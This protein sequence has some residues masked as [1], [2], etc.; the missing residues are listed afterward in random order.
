MDKVLIADSDQ[1]TLEKIKKGFRDLH[2]FEILTAAEGEAALKLLN[3]EKVAVFVTAID[4]PKIPG[5]DLIA[6]MTR[7]RPETPCIVM[8]E[9]NTPKPWFQDRTG[10][11]NVLYYLQKPFQF[12]NLASAIFVGQNLKD[13]GLSRRGITLRNFLPL[14]EISRKTCRLDITSGGQ[15]Q[16]YLY[17]DRGVLLNAHCEDLTGEA[18]AREMTKWDR[19]SLTISELPKEQS[20][21]VIKTELMEIARALWG[22]PNAADG[23]RRP[24]AAENPV[25]R[26]GQTKLQTAVNRY[27]GILRTVKGYKGIAV[28]NSEGSVLASDTLDTSLDFKAFV[29]PFN[30]MLTNCQ[31]TTFQRGFEKCTGLTVHTTKGLILMMASDVMKE[32][33]FRFLVLMEPGG[34]SY[35]MQVQLAKIIPSILSA[36]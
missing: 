24:A 22:R 33:N 18:A 30:Q 34:N 1:E 4:L 31:Q 27:A 32:G 29:G 36:K 15:K 25:P 2:H 3:Q 7:K 13:E 21:K 35:F 11:E 19:V 5:I 14:I 23:Q 6:F 26:A 8:V 20:K 28:L 9:P 12:G 16:G 17:F 10:H